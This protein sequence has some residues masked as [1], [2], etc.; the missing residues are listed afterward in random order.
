MNRKILEDVAASYEEMAD[1]MERRHRPT[2]YNWFAVPDT[3]E[4]RPSAETTPAMKLI[5]SASAQ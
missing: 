5:V 4:L 1:L 3:D 2:D